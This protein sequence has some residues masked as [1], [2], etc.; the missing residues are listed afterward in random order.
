MASID[1]HW[2]QL[3]WDCFHH[4]KNAQKDDSG[5]KE[6]LGNY[7]F[8]ERPQD[9]SAP[10]N[11]EVNDP[12]RF[13]GLLKKGAYDISG[14]P[15]K[16]EAL[17]DY[18]TSLNNNKH[19]F[20]SDLDEYLSLQLENSPC[21]EDMA[22]NVDISPPFVY[23]YPERL[24]HQFGISD[25]DFED[26]YSEVGYLNQYQIILNR[27]KT[28]PGSNRAVATIYNPGLDRERD[29]IP[30]L[31][32]LQ[33]IIREDCLTLHVMFRSNDLYGAWPANMYFLTYL[34]LLLA[35]E[36]E[37]SFD[38]IYYHSSSLHIYDANLNDVKNLLDRV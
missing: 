15:F 30:C 37:V 1:M 3:L 34:G 13:L 25:F 26:E 38:G 35:Q 9:I 11:E 24:I 17:Y 21:S 27:L 2:K 20:C 22:S 18:V 12:D 7:L 29:D 28:N 14:Y 6:L 4:G 5:I 33:A 31:N 36:L 19:I 8:L 10:L 32:W 16:T 23:T